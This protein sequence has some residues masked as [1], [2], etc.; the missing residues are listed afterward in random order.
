MTSAPPIQGED[1]I[2]NEQFTTDN[3]GKILIVTLFDRT[4]PDCFSIINCLEELWNKF[5]GI[6]NGIEV[7]A[8][9]PDEASKSVLDSTDVT[10]RGIH[11]VTS[12]IWN[13]Y[14]GL[15]DPPEIP[16]SFIID[17]DMNIRNI[18]SGSSHPI[19]PSVLWDDL[20]NLITDYVYERE[21]IDLE[22]VL[23]VSGSMN[24]PSPSEPNGASKLFMMKQA[25]SII[26]DFLKQNGQF[27][28]RLGLVWFTDDV[29]VYPEDETLL[30][31]R[32]DWSLLLTEINSQ[33]TGNCTAMG[34]GLQK[35]FDILDP[36]TQKRF[37]IL[38]TD[39]MQNINPLVTK[40][41]DHYEIIGSNDMC[42]PPSQIIGEHPGI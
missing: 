39:G 30:L 35:A 25:T 15:S 9:V 17:R 18:Y 2:N 34:P 37:V 24:N 8:L 41:D 42:G 27:D 32:D 4:V 10:F 6:N 1:F 16:R 19:C 29:S 31:I 11:D 22:M 21:P 7:V 13:N 20:V 28:D 26:G 3:L 36:S 23:D 40:V 14:N 38:C 12:I 33:V 5:G